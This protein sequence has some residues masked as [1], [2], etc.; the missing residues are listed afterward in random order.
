MQAAGA[1]GVPMQWRPREM[2]LCAVGIAA[3]AAI[4]VPNAGVM[5]SGHAVASTEAG[6]HGAAATR[7]G[8]LACKRHCR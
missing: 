5:H 7:T 3:A 2:S 1:A 8:A 6:A 4:L